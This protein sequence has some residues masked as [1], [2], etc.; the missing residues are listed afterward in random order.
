MEL[1][2]PTGRSGRG[3]VAALRQMGMLAGGV[4]P[5]GHNTNTRARARHDGQPLWTM[6]W[7]CARAGGWICPIDFAPFSRRERPADGMTAASV[8][9]AIDPRPATL[10]PVMRNLNPRGHRL[11]TIDQT[12]EHLDES[13]GG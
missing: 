5:V 7:S 9:D 12:D 10:S 1:M 2:A 11:W 4:L 8:Y 13:I 6:R 3:L